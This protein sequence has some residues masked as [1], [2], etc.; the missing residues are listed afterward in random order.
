M[1]SIQRFSPV[2][3][4]V[5][6]R[7][8][9]PDGTNKEKFKASTSK[10]KLEE[11]LPDII[12]IEMLSQRNGLMRKDRVLACNIGI[13]TREEMSALEA[14]D[15]YLSIQDIEGNRRGFLKDS[16]DQLRSVAKELSRAK[17]QL[18]EYSKQTAITL[19]QHMKDEWYRWKKRFVPNEYPDPP[20]GVIRPTPEGIGLPA[21]S[22]IYFVW[23]NGIV[24]YVGQ[25]IKMNNRLRLNDHQAIYKSDFLSFIPFEKDELV[26]AECYYIGMLRPKRNRGTPI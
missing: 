11:I 14:V 24:A 16:T 8:Y 15:Q 9:F 12:L 10:N 1:A 22:G 19:G 2:G 5:R 20:P 4:R 23:E 18:E 3:W 21:T 13:I 6:W 17:E 26:W 7:L 25:S